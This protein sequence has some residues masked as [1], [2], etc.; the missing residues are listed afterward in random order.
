MLAD[1]MSALDDGAAAAAAADILAVWSDAG[2]AAA[3][4]KSE[5]QHSGAEH[6]PVD[7]VVDIQVV[8]TETVAGHEKQKWP[9]DRSYHSD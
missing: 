2:F 3:H 7:L 4:V 9:T 5:T 1:V 8:R 6:S